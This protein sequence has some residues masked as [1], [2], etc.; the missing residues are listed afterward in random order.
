MAMFRMNPAYALTPETMNAIVAFVDTNSSALGSTTVQ[1]PTNRQVLQSQVT[2][3]VANGGSIGI[4]STVKPTRFACPVTIFAAPQ[5]GVA[6]P[7]T[8]ANAVPMGVT[9]TAPVAGEY[10]LDFSG[11]PGDIVGADAN[12]VIGA[13]GAP[14]S[15]VFAAVSAIDN[16]NK[17]VYVQ[18]TNSAGTVAQNQGPATMIT[19]QVT[20]VDSNLAP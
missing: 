15:A 14:A 18:V 5:G 10:V 8:N 9:T 3:N 19:V 11:F 20:I 1:T 4:D 17:L 7:A 12:T 16:V 13:R 2:V 6:G